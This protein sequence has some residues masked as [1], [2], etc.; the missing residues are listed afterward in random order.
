MTTPSREWRHSTRLPDDVLAHV[1]DRL[2]RAVLVVDRSIVRYA[3]GAAQNLMHPIGVRAGDRLADLATDPPLD[4]L[5]HRVFEVGL[6]RDQE[7]TVGRQTF[8]VDGFFDRR[9]GLCTLVVEDVTARSRRFR[10]EQDFVVNAAH[11]ILSPLAAIVGAAEVL[12]N[13]AK[14]D[15]E[16]RDLFLG[17]IASASER[18]TSTAKALLTLAKAEAGLGGPRLELVPLVPLVQEVARGKED[19][20][21][22]CPE[23][24]AVLADVDLVRQVVGILVENAR[25]H[26]EA[27][28]GI[29]VEEIGEKVS[30]TIADLGGGILPENLERVTERFFTADGIDSRGY[31]VGLSIAER[32]MTILGGSLEI[33]SDR[34]G[35]SMRMEL[36]SARLL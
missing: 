28:V 9:A 36:P 7:L 17:H 19:V 21:V 12:Q 35:T 29:T 30:V 13:G 34:S 18:L 10:S 2:T 14:D 23:E 16:A 4:E 25:R 31:G 3:N 15:P 20:A 24:L 8:A 32:A 11:E 26:S 5:A 1:L 6:V 22:T 33:A 27:G